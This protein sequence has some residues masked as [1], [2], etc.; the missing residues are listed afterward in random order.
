[1]MVIETV[2]SA[3]AIWVFGYKCVM[4][5]GGRNPLFRYDDSDRIAF[6]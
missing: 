4:R 5:P 3:D 6:K 1:M 2:Q